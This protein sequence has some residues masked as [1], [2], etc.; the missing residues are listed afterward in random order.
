[1]KKHPSR[2]SEHNGKKKTSVDNLREELLEV[3]AEI[4]AQDILRKFKARRRKNSDEG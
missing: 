2:N 3:L 1:M 4:I